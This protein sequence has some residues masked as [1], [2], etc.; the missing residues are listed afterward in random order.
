MIEIDDFDAVVYD[1]TLG[2]THD[3]KRMIAVGDV[4]TIKNRVDDDIAD[5]LP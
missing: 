5:L 1:G 4:E 3:G 2:I